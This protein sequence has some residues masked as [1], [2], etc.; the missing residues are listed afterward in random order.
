MKS[1]LKDTA[2][3]AF[4]RLSEVK[5]IEPIRA[6]AAMY[7]MVKIKPEVFAD[8]IDDVDFCKKL[9]NEQCCLVFPSQ[10]FFAK[11]FFRVVTCT[12]RKTID[13]FVERL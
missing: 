6:T 10:C 5:G 11:N 9:L 12:T 7:M 4:E 2:D 8:I 1:K 3:Y 13:E